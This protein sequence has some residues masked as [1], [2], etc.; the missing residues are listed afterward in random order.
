MPT[1]LDRSSDT[2]Y[3]ALQVHLLANDN[4]IGRFSVSRVLDALCR[5]NTDFAATGIR[6]YLK[7]ELDTIN[8]TVWWKHDS[9]PQGIDMMLSNN[10]ADALNTY[11][12]SDP[13]GNC[14]YNL[15]YGGVAIAHGCSSPLNHTWAHEVGH[16]LSLPHTFL[17]WEGKTYNFT[18]PTPDTL[19]YDYTY[20]HD[21][22]DT[23]LPVPLDTALVEKVDGS[24][25]ANA[26]DLICDTK[27][28][29]LSYRWDCDTQNNSVVKQRDPNGQVFYADGTLFMSYAADVCQSRF[30]DEQIA[31]M[32]AN[33]QT[34]K[35]NWLYSGPLPPTITSTPVLLDPIDNAPVPNTGVQ[36]H[37]APVVGATH[38]MVQ[39]T[40]IASFAVKEFEL[41]S[42]DTV[43]ELPP[44]AVNKLYYWHVKPFSFWDFCTG[45]SAAETF[46]T[47]AATATT[48]PDAD[49]WRCY[50]TLLEPRSGDHSRDPDF[51][52]PSPG[53]LRTIRYDWSP[54]LGIDGYN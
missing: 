29:Y 38:Y 21:T 20:F 40:R 11:F 54:L 5:L 27:P 28:D 46:M 24:N 31:A 48:S 42:T 35:T 32:R 45:T 44:L 17:G 37:W 34:E 7:N 47:G 3:T 9:I 41:V 19:T 6:F 4:G 22:L 2:L 18:Q 13:A 16:A 30:S 25:C 50:P 53:P 52:A 14:G 1:V 36:L 8:S 23:Q 49:G 39:V 12:V 10:V 15:P 33:L 43:L 51:L 26:A